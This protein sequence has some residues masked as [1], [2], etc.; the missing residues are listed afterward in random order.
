MATKIQPISKT[1][2]I[3]YS[4]KPLLNFWRQRSNSSAN[5]NHRNEIA[6]TLK[7]ADEGIVCI[8][9]GLFT[10]KHL[11]KDI[12]QKLKVRFY[13]LVNEYSQELDLLNE[14]CLI[15]YDLKNN[16]TFILVNPNSDN[17]RG[18]F[19]TGQL[20]EQ[21]LA[22][23]QHISQSLKP[24]E[25]KEL[26]RHFCFHF[27]ETA[28][29]E[30][31]EKGKHNDVTSKPFDVFHDVNTFNGKD[32]VF[33]TVFDY[34]E[35][36][37]R[38]DLSDKQIIYLGQE[39]QIPIQIKSKSTKDLGDFVLKE[40]IPKNE[41]ED[42]EP[43]LT[44]DGISVIIEY[45]WQN[46]PFYLPEGAIESPLYERWRK[47]QEEIVKALDSI[48][49]KIQE[50]EKKLDSIL[51]KIQEA[52]KKEASLSKA[53]RCLF[54]GKKNVLGTSKNDIEKE[55]K[56][57]N[58]ANLTEA[59]LKEKINRINKINAQVQE[60]IGEIE[61]EDRKA[62]L[63]EEIKSDKTQLSKL[64][65]ELESK[66]QELENKKANGDTVFIPKIEDEI[67]NLKKKRNSLK[68]KIQSKE[69]EKEK[70]KEISQSYS[71]S[72]NEVIGDKNVKQNNSTKS[73]FLQVPDLQDYPSL[74]KVGKL[75]QVKNQKFLAI[76]FWE[77]YEIGKKEAER[78]NAI[79]CAIKQ[80]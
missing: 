55:L 35:E 42:K 62:K 7:L 48:L 67:K 25:I 57:T 14:T 8:Q 20:T 44:D 61:T 58:Y 41:F 78:L 9:T 13:I 12:A 68:N 75:Y 47:K 66:E 56:K 72:L 29:K 33:G 73:Q 22:V 11:I 64:E 43:N 34:S 70:Y 76:E 45:K 65:S 23:T 27:W 1:K 36:S 28:K 40:M 30:V 46:V 4:N 79:L 6:E 15:R 5:Q 53:I 3:D 63:D 77:E 38:I 49:N 50:A 54:L 26:F 39:M 59:E 51:N 21:S 16:G 71:S 19:F 80:N 60:K 32:F 17:P 10:D 37:K 52:E 69:K 74:P 2:T 18:I 31:I 24:N